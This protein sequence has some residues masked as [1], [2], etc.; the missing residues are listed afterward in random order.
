MNNIQ[1]YQQKR[2]T[3]EEAV[4]H[5]K[6]GEDII[7]PLIA[8]EPYTLMKQL[9]TYDGLNGNRLFQMLSANE[10]INVAP[11]KLKIISMF[12]G[13]T[14]RKA[15][16][17][18]KIDLLPNHFSDIPRLMIQQPTD[19]VIMAVVSPMDENGY[20][21]LGT[22]CDHTSGILPFAKTVLLEV[23]EN[24]P[25]TFGENQIHISD[26][27][28]LIGS[29]AP[30]PQ[31]PPARLSDKDKVIGEYV[32]ELIKDDDVLQ[33]GFGSIPNAIIDN[34]KNHQNLSI[35]TEMI[36]E[37]IIELFR[38]G[39]VTNANNPFHKG[40]MTATF[41]YGT[42][43]LYDFLHENEDVYMLPVNKTNNAAN[44]AGL[45]NLVTIN[46]AVEVDFLGQANS[47]KV[48]GTYWSS[49]G[50]QS[51]FQLASHL[52]EGG[53]GVLC[54]HSTAKGDSI[55][56]IRPTLDP[57]TPISTS[58]NDIDYVVTEHGIAR[59]RGQTI[60]ERTSELIRIAH[61][62]FRDEL[63]YEAKQMGYL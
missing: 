61:P 63:K 55:S 27:T 28:A 51:D 62:N 4:T 34:L 17:E 44:L 7:T 3:P 10:V 54:L 13:T 24:M 21:S 52:S 36:P 12:M 5:I 60:R 22:N 6:P 57:G 31:A 16:K 32:A 2:T 53:R 9:E 37:K 1:L 20:F 50:G 42:Q 8:G 56:K 48:G 29:D 46:A 40:K 58:K 45:K 41:A 14:E 18:R 25:R 23:N 35:H 47:E 38:N 30:I 15:F 26:V 43:K 49:T 39:S 19:K 11:D 33:I 59:L